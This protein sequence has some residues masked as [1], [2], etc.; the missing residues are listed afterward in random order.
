MSL[1]RFTKPEPDVGEVQTE[2][3][4]V[5]DDALVKLFALGPGAELKPHPHDSSSNVFHI[6]E[7]TITVIQD[8]EEE[9]IEAPGVVFHDRGV[10]HG[11]RNET[12]EPVYFTATLAPFPS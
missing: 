10:L 2:E 4:V 11:A 5:S 8:D 7:G 6:L 1:D 9:E 12:D 3:L